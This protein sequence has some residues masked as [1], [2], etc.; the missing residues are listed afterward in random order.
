MC[1]LFYFYYPTTWAATHH[2]QRICLLFWRVDAFTMVEEELVMA[3]DSSHI[4]MQ[5]MTT[6]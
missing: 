1:D 6:F 3:D 4:T 2:F 5:R